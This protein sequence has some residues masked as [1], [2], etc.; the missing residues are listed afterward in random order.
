MAFVG[1]TAITGAKMALVSREAR[2][3]ASVI[4]REARYVEL[5]LD[6]DFAREFA[7]AMYLPH[8]DLERF[9]SVRRLLER[10]R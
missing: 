4:A 6:A 2:E 10:R 8:R 1:N 9:P 7:N 5:T 3:A